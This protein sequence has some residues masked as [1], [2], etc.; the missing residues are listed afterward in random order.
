MSQKKPWWN[1]TRTRNQSLFLGLL[2]IAVGSLQL[3]SLFTA[4]RASWWRWAAAALLI[5]MA[6]YYLAAWWTRWR[7]EATDPHD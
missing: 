7:R 2:W 1:I 6:S 5:V 3:S 4:N